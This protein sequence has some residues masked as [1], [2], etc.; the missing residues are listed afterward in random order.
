MNYQTNVFTLGNSHA[1]RIPKRILEALSYGDH[2][3]V[4]LSVT[5][6]GSILIRKSKSNGYLSLRERFAGYTGNC[7]CQEWDT[8]Q[9]V[10]KELL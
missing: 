2:E 6:N 7:Q 5:E 4:S 1:V 8:G 3:A 10:G 9:P